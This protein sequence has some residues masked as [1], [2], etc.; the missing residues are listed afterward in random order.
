MFRPFL[1][2][3]VFPVRA[4]LLSF[5]PS[6]TLL[7]LEEACGEDFSWEAAELFHYS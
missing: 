3:P 4:C 5:C 6:R 7:L 1:L 2:S